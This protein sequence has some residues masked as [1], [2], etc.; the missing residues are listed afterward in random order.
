MAVP[1]GTPR[2]MTVVGMGYA[3]SRTV[4]PAGVDGLCLAPQIDGENEG[5]WIV[6]HAESGRFLSVA[7]DMHRSLRLAAGY[8]YVAD[9]TRPLADVVADPD[10]VIACMRI[11]GE[12]R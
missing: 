8:G 2:T 5:G 6:I 1:P 9:W 11:A 7:R 3:E 12:L 10:V 4:W